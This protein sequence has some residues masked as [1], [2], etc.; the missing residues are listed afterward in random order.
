[1]TA[2]IVGKFSLG[3]SAKIK[4]HSIAM[5]FNPGILSADK[6]SDEEHHDQM[7]CTPAHDEQMK[8][9]VKAEMFPMV[10]KPGELQGIDDASY[11]VNNAAG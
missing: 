9:L 11:R 2:G 5:F 7:A 3:L 4:K 6:K 10:F 8:N 1:M